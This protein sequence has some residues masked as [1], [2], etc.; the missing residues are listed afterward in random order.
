MAKMQIRRYNPENNKFSSQKMGWRHGDGLKDR[1][2][3]LYK[4]AISDPD[5]LSL[6][7]DLALIDV[8]IFQIIERF[9][10]VD[11]KWIEGVN[12]EIEKNFRLVEV[13]LEDLDN[14]RHEELPEER[15]SILRLYANLQERA[16]GIAYSYQEIVKRIEDGAE[17]MQAWNDLR[18][19]LDRRRKTVSDEVRHRIT[20]KMMISSDDAMAIGANL[21]KAVM[22]KVK[23]PSLL[24]EIAREFAAIMGWDYNESLPA[25][26][27]LEDFN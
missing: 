14:A 22:K 21:L 20:Q 16:A 26:F 11:S 13:L 1:A 27:G 5:L 8:R 4:S 2:Y 24:N 3:D 10:V 6:R 9:G 17:E 15:D 12:K 25:D 23:D 7:G 18:P 19:W